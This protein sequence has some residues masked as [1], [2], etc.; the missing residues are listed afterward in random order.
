M[1]KSGTKNQ[2]LSGNNSGT[3]QEQFSNI[4]GTKS[5]KKQLYGKNGKQFRNILEQNQEQ[6]RTNSGQIQEQIRN[7]S[8]KCQGTI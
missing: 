8:G 2:E 3:I 5:Y 4:Y 7:K 1:N 6:F